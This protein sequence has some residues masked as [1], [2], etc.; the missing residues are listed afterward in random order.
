MENVPVGQSIYIGVMWS[1]ADVSVSI[2]EN[3]NLVTVVSGE[4]VFSVPIVKISVRQNYTRYYIVDGITNDV[5]VRSD[6][7]NRLYVTGVLG[8]VE[9]LSKPFNV[10]IV[11]IVSVA[12]ITVLIVAIVA[13]KFRGKITSPP[14]KPLEMK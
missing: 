4:N 10:L 9:I 7:P 5:Y 2:S 11:V 6:I 13:F 8:N 12:I 1:I 14:E 3:E